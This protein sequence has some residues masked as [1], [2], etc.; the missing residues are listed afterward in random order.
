MYSNGQMKF[1]GKCFEKIQITA[2]GTLREELFERYCSEN[3]F[4]G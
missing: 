2:C 4:F 3:D 1:L